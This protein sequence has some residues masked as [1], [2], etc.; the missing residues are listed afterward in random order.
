VRTPFELVARVA[1]A[2]LGARPRADPGEGGERLG[3]PFRRL[4]TASGGG[5]RG[6]GE[7]AATGPG[8]RLGLRPQD[9][10][11]DGQPRG[12]GRRAALAGRLDRVDTAEG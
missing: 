8:A 1:A 5:D 12:Q 4:G 9:G 2:A 10:R 3:P 7:R 11:L 6:G